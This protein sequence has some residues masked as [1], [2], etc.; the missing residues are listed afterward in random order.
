MRNLLLFITRNHYFFLFVALEL[1]AFFILIR[2]NNYQQA[3]FA[4]STNEFTGS[5]EEA[6]SNVTSYFGLKEANEQLV[7]ENAML[8]SQLGTSWYNFSNKGN[9]V[10]DTFYKQKYRYIPG[11]VVNKS[12]HKRNNYLTVNRGSSQGVSRG[13]GVICPDGVV[14]IVKEVSENFCTVMSLLHDKVN[15][16]SMIKKYGETGI[17]RWEGSDE[18]LGYLPNIPSHLKLYTNDTIVTSSSSSVF[19]VGIPVGYIETVEIIPGNTFNNITVRLS[20]NFKKLDYVYI[21]DYLYKEEQ[22]NLEK[23]TLNDK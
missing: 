21:V 19:P 7:K 6:Y 14:G 2:N 15:I 16:P 3:V 17:L 22:D 20:T 8:R 1:F 5:I 10:N 11:N 4:N 9:F 18:R 12:T 23:K 13:M